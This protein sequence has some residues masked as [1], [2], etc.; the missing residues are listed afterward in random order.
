MDTREHIITGPNDWLALNLDEDEQKETDPVK[1]NE[2]KHKKEIDELKKQKREIEQ[3]I[4]ALKTEGF[5]EKGI[6]RLQKDERKQVWRLA[7]VTDYFAMGP[8]WKNT[9]EKRERWNP[10]M[11]TK[12]EEEMIC[13]IDEVIQSLK[14]LSKKI[15]Q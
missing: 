15:N 14:G 5:Q 8:G 6:A 1:A 10:I 7:I 9:L 4:R 13:K 2:I 11:E 12:T 3:K